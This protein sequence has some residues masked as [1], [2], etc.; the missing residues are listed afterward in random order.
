M[1]L[2]E[3]IKEKPLE[4]AKDESIDE[5]KEESKEEES[6]KAYFKSFLTKPYLFV[7]KTILNS[8]P[9]LTDAK[10]ITLL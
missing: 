7:D 6:K 5:S 3:E 1:M 8:F 10:S 9:F 2:E 4:E